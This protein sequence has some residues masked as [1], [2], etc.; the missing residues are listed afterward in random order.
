[1]KDNYPACLVCQATSQEVPL[2]SLHYREQH[3]FICPGHFPI[4]I[5]QPQRLVGILPGAEKLTPQ[6]H[7]DD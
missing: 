1:M 3:F 7:H 4:L 5:H 2:L 6:D